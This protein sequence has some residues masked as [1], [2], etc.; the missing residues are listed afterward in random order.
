MVRFHFYNLQ[1]FKAFDIKYEIKRC[2][3]LVKYGE[4][5]AIENSPTNDPSNKTLQISC[6]KLEGT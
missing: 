1:P 6:N 2:I 4:I 3:I 5:S